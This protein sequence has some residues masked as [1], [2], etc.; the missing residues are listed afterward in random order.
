MWRLRFLVSAAVAAFLS[1][2]SWVHANS[3]GSSSPTPGTR[4]VATDPLNRQVVEFSVSKFSW[5]RSVFLER[6]AEHLPKAL[7]AAANPSETDEVAVAAVVADLFG[8]VNDTQL[9]KALEDAKKEKE[10]IE[11][12]S[13]EERS[14]ADTEYA[15]FLE[16]LLWAGRLVRLG[17][18]GFE[19]LEGLEPTPPEKFSAFEKA[20]R[21]AFDRVLDNNRRFHELVDGIRRASSDGERR[22]L[23]LDLTKEYG[24][25]MAF[26]DGQVATSNEDQTG[27][28]VAQAVAEAIAQKNAEGHHTI[29]LVAKDSNAAIRLELGKDP[30]K[31][32]EVLRDLRKEIQE[33]DARGLASTALALEPHAGNGVQTFRPKGASPPPPTRSESPTPPRTQSPADQ[34]ERTPFNDQLRTLFKVGRCVG[35]HGPDAE[36]DKLK[37]FEENG[38]LLPDKTANDVKRLLEV[39]DG[40]G[41]VNN[42]GMQKTAETFRKRLK[43]NEAERRALVNWAL[44]NGFDINL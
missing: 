30:T 10:R 20:F 23:Q 25:V 27:A 7:Q 19:F 38:D 11:A 36:P 15:A 1:N 5:D 3:H 31:F 12:K 14:T 16:R 2:G 4:P 35:C 32:L 33:A 40:R 28:R 43:E 29:D 41:R 9:K 39:I 37:Y 42:E 8:T 22:R 34:K 17:I 24:S 21:K 6:H 44:E 18:P 13:E 26:L